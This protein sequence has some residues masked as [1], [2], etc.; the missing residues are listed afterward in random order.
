MP[1]N[2]S[3]KKPAAMLPRIPK[4][5]IHQIVSCPMDVEA[6]NTASMVFKKA[7]I[8]RVQSKAPANSGQSVM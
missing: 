1:S 5:L 3:K 7:L 6:V 8:E 4:E 2:K